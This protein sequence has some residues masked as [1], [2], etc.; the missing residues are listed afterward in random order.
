[1]NAGIRAVTRVGIH[2]GFSMFGIERGY[3]GIINEDIH[4]L[5]HRDVARIINR[6]GTMLR[7]ARF[8]A[9]KDPAVQEQAYAILKDY[10]IDGLVIL[11]GDG[12]MAGAKAL[13]ALG[14]PTITVPCTIDNDMAGTQLTIGFDS[15]VNTIL[16]CVSRIRDTS[17]AHERVAVIEVMGRNSGRLALEAGLACGAEVVL[18]PEY[19]VSLTSV[20]NHLNETHKHG[21]WYSLILVA[22]G[23]YNGHEVSEFIKKHTYLETSVTVL[24][25]VQRG[26]APTA[27]DANLGTVLGAYA[28]ECFANGQYNGV[29]GYIDGRTQFTPYSQ[30]SNHGKVISKDMY[31]LVSI[32]SS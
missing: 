23:A 14:L 24:G 31:E 17:D 9:F 30:L 6:G 27:V 28:M 16:N 18:I 26:G 25:Y 3:E 7:T 2:K 19:E 12:S 1:M 13:T 11:G 32:L 5:L 29:V 20:C 15:A 22:E 10:G 8:P 4:P 21:K